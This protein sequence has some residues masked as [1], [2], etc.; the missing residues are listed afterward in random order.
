MPTRPEIG[1][2]VVHEVEVTADMTARLFDREI[3]PLYAT[4]WLVRHVEEAGRLIVERRL[5]P[6]EDA[7]GYHIEVTHEGPARVGDRL[8]IRAWVT[9]ADQ[10]SCTV[11]FEA[12]GPN[13]LVGRGTF[14]QRYVARKVEGAG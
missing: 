7:T 4:A 13:G 5:D 6:E 3:H 10:R 1:E 8:S 12:T 14:V 2:E 9:E 11:A